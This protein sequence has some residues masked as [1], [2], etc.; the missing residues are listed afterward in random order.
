MASTARVMV[1]WNGGE[2]GTQELAEGNGFD[3]AEREGREGLRKKSESDKN[4]KIC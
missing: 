3:G 4:V 1:Q 2:R